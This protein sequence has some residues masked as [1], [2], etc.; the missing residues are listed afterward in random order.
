MNLAEEVMD[1]EQVCRQ[2]EDQVIFKGILER[3]CLGWM[4]AHDEARWEI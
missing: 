2:T 4:N 3:V 1:L